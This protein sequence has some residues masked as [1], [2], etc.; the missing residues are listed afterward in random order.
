MPGDTNEFSR[1]FGQL[2]GESRHAPHPWQCELAALECCENQLIRIPTGFGKTLGVLAAWLWNAHHRS[3]PA[4]PRRLV[5][6]LPM[7]VLVEQTE[8]EIRSALSSLGILWDGHDDHTGSVGVHS[9]MG[10]R[11]DQEWSLHPERL[12]ILV[13]TQDMLLSRAMNRGY[14][15]PRARWPMEF[16]LLNQDCLWVMDEVQLMD[17]GLATSGQLQAFRDDDEA[18][19]KHIR[20]CRTW[21][22]S[23]TLQRDWLGVSPD[24][25]QLAA[26]LPS[27]RIPPSNRTGPLWDGVTKPLRM[28]SASTAEDIANLVSREHLARDRGADG[29]SLVVV[30]TVKQAVEVHD[31]LAKDTRLEGTD[32]RLVHSRFRPAD[33]APWREAFLNRSACAPG[34]DRIIVA[35]QVIEAGVDISAALLITTLA[36]WASLVQRFGRAARWGGSARIIVVDHLPAHTDT[37][38]D[39]QRK[40]RERQAMPY[41]LGELDAAREALTQMSDVSPLGLE[42]FEESNPQLLARLYPY[43]A[44]H[45][46][47]RHELEELFDTT[48]DLSG[49]DIDISRF[50]RSGEERDL[51]VFWADVP[52]DDRYPQES[53]MPPRDALC[54]VPFLAAREWLC[55]KETSTSKA[56]RLRERMRAWVWDYLDGGWRV[57][58]R[59][60]LFP[61]QTV[62]VAA[63]SGGYLTDTGWSPDS[64]KQVNVITGVAPS[65]EDLTEAS[66]DNEALSAASR[67]QTIATHGAQV[68]GE[69][70]S[71]TRVLG[72][73][74]HNVF[75][76]AGRWHDAG[77][78]LPPFQ[79]SIQSAIGRGDLAKAPKTAW[80]DPRQLYP[81]PPRDRRRGFRHE[82][83][84]TL[85]LFD[86][87]IRHQQDHP[88]LL[89]PWR[90]LLEASGMTVPETPA[91]TAAP[92]ALEQE[93]LDL[94]ADAFDLLAYLV[95]SHHG[96]V[97][98]A[99]HASQA[100]QRASD[101][102]LRLRGVRDGETLPSLALMDGQGRVVQL[103]E[104]TLRLDAAAV[105]LNPITGRG[106]TERVLGLLKRHGPFTLAFFE[107]LLR[108]AD[109][110]ASRA[111]VHD[112]LLAPAPPM[113]ASM[114][115]PQQG[116][117]S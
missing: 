100:D 71:M 43:N 11:N 101:M 24:T 37:D 23:A 25:K 105:G 13:G 14:A 116:A 74:G 28:E 108:A 59:K 114:Q 76:L 32:L 104:S 20:P 50:I 31:M 97:R 110:R 112:P 5:W 33:R 3:D 75:A 55:G 83:A 89:G 34:T 54:R 53:S 44:R 10:G 84:S 48:P 95:C 49:A 86:V 6:C 35:T 60:D 90:A 65:A 73:S 80:L 39:R 82:L 66:E 69:V 7:R 87:L 16:G 117:T 63:D 88:A 42:S 107:A 57:A 4:W 115:R 62:L 1:W 111:P 109:Q 78:A 17:V 106:W 9:V 103:P 46:L 18:A 21:W 51:Q 2:S 93:V 41:G 45:L 19:G 81:D 40:A 99:W 68:G 113:P 30:N 12:G 92:N 47:L 79:A 27:I 38:D 58:E 52:R 67:W 26:S 22:M 64:K 15:S 102:V 96:K 72:I 94:D 61:G 8:A 77:K 29:P 56:P 70:T 36:P 91:S 98:M 85:A